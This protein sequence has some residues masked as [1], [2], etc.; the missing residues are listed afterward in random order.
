MTP[1]RLTND[2]GGIMR[3]FGIGGG[4]H[5]AAGARST[6]RRGRRAA[7]LA[8]LALSLLAGIATAAQAPFTGTPFPVPGLIEAENFDTGGEGVA[9]H[10]AVPGNAGGQYRTD[11][12]VDIIANGPG[13]AVN[14]FQTGEW[15]EYTI[16]V[17]QPGVHRLELYVSSEYTTS[18]WHAEIDG[19]AVTGSVPVPH[20]GWWGTFQWVG[21]SGV[22]FTAGQH[23]LRIHADQEYFNFDAIRVVATQ[24]PFGGVPFAVPGSIEAEDFDTGGEGIA[25]HDA[26]AGNAGGQYRTDT[27]VDIIT[28]GLGYAINNFQTGEWLEYTINVTQPGTHRLELHVS[29]E[30][31]TSRWHAEIDGVAATGSVPVPHTGLWGIFQWVG[32]DNVS[33]TAGQHVLRIYADQEYF[34]F[35]AIRVVASSDTTPPTVSITSPASGS[36]V[37]GTITVS[38]TASDNM[39]V[40]GVQFFVDGASLGAEDTT[41][42]YAVTWDTTAAANGAHTLTATARDAAGNTATSAPVSVTVSNGSAS[43]RTFYVSPTAGNDANDGLSPS[44]PWRTLGRARSVLSAGDTLFLRGG[45]YVTDYFEPANAG[46]PGRPI[47][48]TAYPGETPVITGSPTFDKYWSIR[49][50]WFVIDGIHFKDTSGG[51]FVLHIDGASHVTV[52]DCVFMNHAGQTFI[53]LAGDHNIV[54]GSTF[55]RTGSTA[56]EGSG[57]G[58]Y[59]LG[60]AYNLI[61]GNRF[62]R[63]G[64]YALDLIDFGGRYSHHNIIR[65]NVIDHMIDQQRGGGGGI[66][67]IRG[68]HDNLIEGNR[69]YRAGKGVNYVKPGIQLA[70]EANILRRNIIVETD[71]GVPY[72]GL[73][74]N[75]YSFAGIMQNARDNRVYHNVIYKSAKS[76]VALSQRETS[77]VADNKFVNNIFFYNRV[78]GDFEEFWPAGNY[79]L[80]FET[81]WAT[82]KWASFANGNRFLG[83]LILH[84]DPL[85]EYP[86]NPRLIYYDQDD[87]ADSLAG[88]QARY[89][90]AFQGNIAQ[91]PRFMNAEGGDFHLQAGSPAIDRGIHLAR[92]TAAGASTTVVPVDDSRFFSD[93]F[94]IV[95]GD[96]VQVGANPS[97]EVTAVDHAARR[98][99]LAAPISFAAGDPVNLPYSGTAPDMGAFEHP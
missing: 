52:T 67:I 33:F 15:L 19:A 35:D 68:S 9:Y 64:H 70:A 26:V 91:N 55:D 13:Y 25:Y 94:G 3:F 21:V 49:W 34:N 50:D 31:T 78:K 2:G 32:V 75:G 84:A 62:F 27:D 93:G 18:R 77:V 23:V 51:N 53:G 66:G 83:N 54:R 61:E 41:A 57:D 72:H 28:N 92:T 20:T 88:V 10:D 11:T 74:V 17:T 95:P 1:H 5:M 58:I 39:G 47:T 48:L 86:D 16:N 73:T 43:G 60:G 29:S 44:T 87:Y 40:A 89:P 99:T 7:V 4:A 24:T 97:V 59:V 63:A 12:D 8:M 82:T 6:V 98:L 42:P 71:G 76:A 37:S 46:V 85:G 14:N 65:D 80:T 69:I 30:Y 36:T 81:Y 79:Y 38:A 45:N 90:N 22:S 96:L 56:G